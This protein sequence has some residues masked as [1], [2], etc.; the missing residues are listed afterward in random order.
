MRS[1]HLT[2]A[3]PARSA[4]RL[5]IEGLRAVAVGMVLIYHAGITQLPGGFVGVDV[6]FVISGF[7]ITGLLVRESERDGRVSLARFYA[8]RA[9]RLLPA[10]A[11]VLVFAAAITAWLLPASTVRAF[12]YDIV[13]AALSVVNWLFAARSIDYGAQD[14]GASPVLH[15]W[16]L[17][18]EEQFYVVWPLVLLAAL[19]IAKRTRAHLRGAMAVGLVLIAVPSF[20]WAI[21]LGIAQD[22]RGYFVTTTRLWELAIGGLIAVLAPYLARIPVWLGHTLGLAGL[23]AIVW[24]GFFLEEA[25]GWP[26]VATLAPVLGTGAVI[27]AGFG[28]SLASRAL[29]WKP[30]VWIGGISYSLY[31]WHWPLL[32]AARDGLG[33]TRVRWGVAAVLLAVLLAWITQRLIEN[34]ARFSPRLSKDAFTPLAVGAACSLLAVSA[35]LVV[36]STARV[37]APASASTTSVE[38]SVPLGASALGTDPASSPA[39][40]PRIT[41]DRIWQDLSAISSDTPSYVSADCVSGPTESQVKPCVIGEEGSSVRLAAIG[42]SKLGQWYDVLDEVGRIN[43]WEITM[44]SKSACP[45][46]DAARI[47]DGVVWEPCVE[48]NDAMLA[49]LLADPPDAV[50]TSQGSAW[51]VLPEHYDEDKERDDDG[52]AGLEQRWETLAEAGIGVVAL[53]DNPRAPNGYDIVTCLADNPDDATACAFPREDALASS[54]SPAQRAAAEAVESATFVDVTDVIC[55]QD[56]CAPIIGD[57]VV[58]RDGAHITNTYALSTAGVTAERLRAGAAALGI[59]APGAA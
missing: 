31:L 51:G 10:A 19:W 8:R 45:F 42:D 38:G 11:T 44:Y 22:P 47:R 4:L 56:M 27:V 53:S 18:V 20:W 6:F 23:A 40:A 2:S 36:A 30:F 59:P 7:L 43:G 29:S 17:A 9:R 46:S 52:L 54:A 50:I 41:Y 25:V 58:Y 33:L 37:G 28:P 57:V 12:G 34:P 21:Q 26:G 16:S 3:K 13:G 55:P 39:G 48:W 15:Y 35:G 24:S 1:P 5:D 49:T 32:V 14:M